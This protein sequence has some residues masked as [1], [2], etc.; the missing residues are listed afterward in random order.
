MEGKN[1]DKAEP[2]PIRAAI[3][4]EI[5]KKENMA[6]W[7]CKAVTKEHGEHKRIRVLC[8]DEKER[9]FIKEAVEKIPV[10]GL[11]LLRD[12]WYLFRIDN[13]NKTAVLDNIGNI[14]TNAIDIFS[15][16]NDVRIAKIV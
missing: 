7:K 14:K 10:R 6:D 9:Q 4:S 12:Q 16:E 11:R 1:A 3:E 13:I 8:Q 2:G 15:K 5:R